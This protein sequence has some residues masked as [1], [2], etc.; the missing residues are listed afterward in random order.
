MYDS[1][2]RPVSDGITMGASSTF[3]SLMMS[4][5]TPKVGTSSSTR[6]QPQLTSSSRGLTPA[7]GTA[8]E[9][10]GMFVGVMKSLEELRQDMTKRIDRSQERAQKGHHS[11]SDELVDAKSQARSDQA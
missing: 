3:D 8:R 5:G 1:L 4:M 6:L 2:S 7:L 11:L 10:S 9:V